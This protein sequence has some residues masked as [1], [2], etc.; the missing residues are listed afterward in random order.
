MIDELLYI[1]I[2][3]GNKEDFGCLS[4]LKKTKNKI[5]LIGY[6]I[7]DNKFTVIYNN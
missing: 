7:L 3:K 2:D 1:G 6:K 4:L 5:Y